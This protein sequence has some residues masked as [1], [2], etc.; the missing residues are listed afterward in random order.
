MIILDANLLIYAYD[1]GAKEHTAARRWL[2]ELFSSPQ[3]I[4]LP[5]QTLGAFLRI[6]THSRL[7][8]PR[9]SIEEAVEIVDEWLELPQLRL[10]VPGERHWDHLRR[11]LLEGNACGPL[12]TDAQI[13]AVA[14]EFSGI[15]H[16]NDRDFARFPGL[17]WANPLIEPK[18]P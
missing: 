5:I 18:Q 7:P 10:L 17:R 11:A 16:T 3:M 8:G 14:L 12:V 9:F 13:A 4:G 2:E 15:V 1:A 6:I